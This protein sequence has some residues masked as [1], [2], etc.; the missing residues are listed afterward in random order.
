ME[1]LRLAARCAAAPDK[2]PD[3]HCNATAER[4]LHSLWGV[5]RPSKSLPG[6]LQPRG[7]IRLRDGIMSVD[8]P[9]FG[10]PQSSGFS[11][12]CACKVLTTVNPSVNSRGGQKSKCPIWCRLRELPSHF[13]FSSCTQ[14]CTQHSLLP[15]VAS[16][17]EC[18]ASP[19]PS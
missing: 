16:W 9:K 4:S 10:E 19:T 14:S 13:S 1:S 8:S 2:I 7:R 3:T 12:P 15:R 17:H 5:D 11:T 18:P 6:D